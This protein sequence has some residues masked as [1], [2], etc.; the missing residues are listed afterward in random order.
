MQV[1]PPLTITD[2]MFTSST[3]DE[4]VAATYNAG[5]TYDTGD[6]AGAAPVYGSAQT[7]WESLQ[8]SNTGNT[9]E[10]GVWWTNKGTVYPV[11]NSGSSCDTG[12][13]VTD[14]TNHW[15]YTSLVDGNTGNPLT[16]TTK[17]EF[18]GPSNKWA[19]F[20]YT[21]NKQT[22]VPLTFTVVFAP[23]VRVNSLA[24][25]RIV[26]DSY[27]LTV[28]SSD[29]GGTIY[30]SSG[31]LYSRETLTW[32]DYFFGEFDTQQSLAFFDI[33]P[34]ADA[35]FTLTLTAASGNVSLGACVIGNFVYLGEALLSAVSDVINFSSVT[36][37]SDGEAT[38]SPVRN[39][40]KTNQIVYC[41]KSR[42]NKVRAV[43]EELNGLPAFWFGVNDDTDG[44]FESL[45]MLGY[46]RTFSINIDMPEKAAINLEVEEI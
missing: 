43:R 42:V 10:E 9:Q 40:P 20:Y 26:A 37:T 13:I 23:G 22:T 35:I 18:S 21:R 32:Y 44:Y 8:D 46:Y 11:Y 38:M 30:S 12:G 45:A 2:A 31:S 15:L 19:L 29:Y 6:R 14:T 39:I 5:T 33:P 24:L 7:V 4:T 36:R 3:V 34:Y 17:W 27:T 28:T 1:I 41:D 16:D 25:A